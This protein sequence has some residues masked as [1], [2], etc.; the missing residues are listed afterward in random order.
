MCA[1]PYENEPG[2]ESPRSDDD[3]K[4]KAHYIQKIRHETLRLAIV[5]RLEEWLGIHADGRVAKL[6]TLTPGPESSGEVDGDEEPAL[7]HFKDLCKRRFLWYYDSYLNCVDQFEKDVKVGE[8]FQRMPFENTSNEMTGEFNYPDLRRRL[9]LVR[10][11]LIAKPITGPRRA[12]W[13]RSRTP[14]SPRT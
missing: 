1:S 6:P 11:I 8:A 13:R 14:A 12:R 5:Q 10:R 4:N 9:H 3:K 7:E 2:F